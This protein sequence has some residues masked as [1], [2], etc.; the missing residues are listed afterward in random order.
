VLATEGLALHVAPRSLGLGTL[1]T[2]AAGTLAV[3]WTLR[4]VHRLSLR[5]LLSGARE[6]WS[7]APA[8]RRLVLPL[9]LG[10][11]GALVGW[12][13]RAERLPQTAGFFGGGSL[14]LM[15][16][17]LASRALIGGRPA[18][19]AA[20][21]SVAALGRR[22]ASFRPGRSALCVGLLAGATFV[23]VAVGA[24]RRKGI[25]MSPSGEAGGYALFA[26]SLQPLDSDPGTAEGRAALGLSGD[27]LRDVSI[28]GFRARRGEDASCLNLHRPQQ[29]TV[30]A[31]GSAFLRA[32]RFSFQASLAE[33]AVE[34]EN[35]WLLLEGEARDGAIP[36]IA[37]A[38]AL[39]YVLHRKLGDVLELGPGGARLRFVGALR[40]GLL[41][42]EV[43]VGE[44]HF[45]KAFPSESGYRFFLVEAPAARVAAVASHLESRLG[46]FG[47]DVAE[48][49]ARLS[50]FHRVENMYISTFQA[51]GALG[52]LLGTAG[53]AAVL[54][55]NALEQRRELALLRA[56]GYEKAQLLTMV[57]AENALLLLLGFAAGALPALVAIEPVLEAQRGGWPVA[58][59]LSL[60]AALAITGAVVSFGAVGVIRRMPLLASLRAE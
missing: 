38:S 53:L 8:M 41:Q 32:G 22:G 7:R 59:I 3:V 57:L 29:P 40:P 48:A 19:A 56:V 30:L 50:A 9:T 51:L 49:A 16:A 5:A 43:L 34:R 52:L 10:V 37:D 60:A 47:L 36:T 46:D 15:S 11:A 44:G 20:I 13:A 54:V 1:G 26:W 42:G 23:I 45:H 55:R 2:I 12:A 31:P 6:A 39:A 14:L 18:A 4:D 25:D 17:V 35:P 27:E 21:R 33:T 28:V 24:F 58:L